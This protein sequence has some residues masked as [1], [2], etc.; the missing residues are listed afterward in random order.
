MLGIQ[1]IN[2][3]KGSHEVKNLKGF[4]FL[5]I[6]NHYSSSSFIFNCSKKNLHCY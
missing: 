5:T 4:F 2:V 1:I 6:Q 3:Y